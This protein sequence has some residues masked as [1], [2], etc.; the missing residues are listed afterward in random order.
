MEL[1]TYIEANNIEQILIDIRLTIEQVVRAFKRSNAYTFWSGY[2]PLPSADR[3][4]GRTWN[5]LDAMEA[6]WKNLDEVNWYLLNYGN[7]GVTQ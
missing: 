6:P 1:L 4:L 3:N 2:A 5:K 7:L